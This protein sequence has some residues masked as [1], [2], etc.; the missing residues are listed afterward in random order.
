MTYVIFKY[1]ITSLI[2]VLVSEFAKKSDN[3][4]IYTIFRNR[5]IVSIFDILGKCIGFGGRALD[6]KEDVK[7]INSFESKEGMT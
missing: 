4:S 5:A 7:Y 6:P 3:G 1:A 2:I